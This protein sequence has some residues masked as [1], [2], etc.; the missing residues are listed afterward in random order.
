MMEAYVPHD[1][2]AKGEPTYLLIDAS[3]SP[4]HASHLPCMVYCVY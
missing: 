2:T 1:V 3:P 4:A